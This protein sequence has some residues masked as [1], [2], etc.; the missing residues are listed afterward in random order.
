M[1]TNELETTGV[2]LSPS[3]LEGL[4]LRSEFIFIF[5]NFIFIQACKASIVPVI[6]LL[7]LIYNF[8]Q[9]INK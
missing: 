7:Y 6:L 9:E 3:P 2:T 8:P 1:K 5:M 4:G